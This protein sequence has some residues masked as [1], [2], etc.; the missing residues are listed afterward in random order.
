MRCSREPLALLALAAAC[1]APPDAD[2]ASTTHSSTS[3]SSSDSSGGSS[4]ESPTTDELDC[5]PLTR[6]GA[7]CVDLATDPDNCGD[8]GI[9][10]RVDHAAAACMNHVCTFAACDPGHEDC[11]DQLING[12]ETTVAAGESCPLVCA[13]DLPE[14]CNLFDDDCDGLCDDMAANC[15]QPVH[16]AHSD[17]LG[18]LYTL[19]PREAAAGDYTI[20][21]LAY[22]HLYTD[23]Q[24]GLVPFHRC[25]LP[26]GFH[27]Y[28]TSPTC[29]EI[30]TP[31][32]QL[33]HLAPTPLCGATPLY[34][35]SN[36]TLTNYLYTTDIAERD[37]AITNQG[38]AYEAIAGY[39]WTSP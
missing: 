39:V 12:C 10:C 4:S 27:Y 35:L 25:L 5:G 38:Y 14:R 19:D 34:R 33:G 15:R 22:F 16:R 1:P 30:A 3:D 21:T 32:G 17:T 29:E 11:D 13:P 6:C 36:G 20:D 2:P 23:P 28:T 26:D 24:P 37:D 31:E 8:C 9:A 7:T 18:R